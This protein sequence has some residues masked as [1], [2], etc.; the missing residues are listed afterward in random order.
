MINTSQST[1]HN[2]EVA[3]LIAEVGPLNGQ[4]WSLGESFLIGRDGSCN[5]VI[6]DRQVSRHHA[7]ITCELDGIY[8]EDL[9]SKNGTHLNGQPAFEKVMLRDGDSIQIALVQ[10][11]T[12]VSSDA[13][14]PLNQREAEMKKQLLMG[15][16][17]APVG[18]L[19]L[20]SRAHRV[21]VYN[22]GRECEIIPPLSASQFKLLERLY[23]APSQVI[24]RHD[25]A[26][27]VWGE[28]EAYNIS[29]QALDA[30][31]RRLRERIDEIDGDNT[32]I[33]TVRG[34]GLRL[35]NPSRSIG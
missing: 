3:M 18:R 31:V 12:F 16:E 33:V 20:D 21:W 29:E 25:L 4:R 15:N 35:D 5:L 30:L 32:Y 6:S 26:T 7:R 24:S 28:K 11:L 14:V 10:T 17:A 8:L 19:R 1:R 2:D 34:H 9:N 13:T 27:V 22:E 23:Q